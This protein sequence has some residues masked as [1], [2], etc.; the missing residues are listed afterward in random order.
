MKISDDASLKKFNVCPKAIRVLKAWDTS[1]KLQLSSTFL[2]GFKL[3]YC[4][5][6]EGLFHYLCYVL[7]F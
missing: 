5:H 6:S 4:F 2:F 3:F 1:E 7:N